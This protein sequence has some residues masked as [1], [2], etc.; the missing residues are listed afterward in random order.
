M[1]Y[2]VTVDEALGET[3]VA[4]SSNC[5]TDAFPLV[6]TLILRKQDIDTRSQALPLAV[7]LLTAPYCG[8]IFEFE[9]IRIGNDY[10]EAIRR[11]IG[12]DVTVLGVDGMHRKTSTG[13]VDIQCEKASAG[14]RSRPAARPEDSVPLARVDW[15]GDPVDR[16][17]RNSS[18]SAQGAIHTNAALFADETTVSVAIALLYGRDSVRTIYVPGVEGGDAVVE[19]IARALRPVSVG[20]DAVWEEP[21]PSLAP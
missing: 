18:D 14:S 1:K 19:R 15:S 4:L 12:R 10:A 5:Y 3:R 2:Q 6:N 20:V 11:V 17:T 21:A 7:A 13:E 9:G 8:E 16:A